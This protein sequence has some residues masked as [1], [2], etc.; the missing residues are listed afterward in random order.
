MTASPE[1]A[2][3]ARAAEAV[4]AGLGY[5]AAIDPAQLPTSAL[6]ELLQIL[7][8]AHALETAARARGLGAFAAAQG[9]HEDGDYSPR[10]WLIKPDRDHQGCRH[11]LRQLGA[12]G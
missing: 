9:C 6:A 12:P 1:F 10:S 8:Q 4:R 7:E 2:S 3:P 5:L 11:R